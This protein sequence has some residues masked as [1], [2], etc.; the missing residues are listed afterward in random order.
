ML[1][2]SVQIVNVAVEFWDAVGI[3]EEVLPT[4]FENG[5]ISSRGIFFM[6]P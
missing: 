1:L 2:D 4:K 3:I 5:G 6:N